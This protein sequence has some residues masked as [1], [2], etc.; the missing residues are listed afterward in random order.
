MIGDVLKS[1]RPSPV[2]RA[3]AV[4][5][6]VG[7]FA[8]SLGYLFIAY[9]LCAD[10]FG[11]CDAT[12][13]KLMYAAAF[14]ACGV[15]MLIIAGRYALAAGVLILMTGLALVAEITDFDNLSGYFLGPFSLLLAVLTPWW[16]YVRWAPRFRAH[17]KVV[18]V[19]VIVG[20]AGLYLGALVVGRELVA[21]WRPGST[22]PDPLGRVICRPLPPEVVAR[23]EASLT[24]PGGGSL[25][26]AQYV[27]SMVNPD[28]WVIAAEVQGV[29][30]DGDDDLGVW[31]IDDRGPDGPGRL[32]ASDSIAAVGAL[33]AKVT[34]LPRDTTTHGTNAEARAC[35]SAALGGH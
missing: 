33:A 14:G 11:G 35:V 30:Y 26:G 25:R 23:L 12:S 32:T 5:A 24:I 7:T 31:L 27:R 10:V 8:L 21:A 22:L 4:L 34:A 15:V 3:A 28:I 2:V 18:S 1:N 16:A 19:I 17:P 20:A 13:V 6:A 29:G 9:F